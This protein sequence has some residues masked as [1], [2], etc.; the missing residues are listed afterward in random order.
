LIPIDH[1]SK[2]SSGHFQQ[3]W[4]PGGHGGVGGGEKAAAPLSDC[5]LEWMFNKLNESGSGLHFDED[6]IQIP[7]SPNQRLSLLLHSN[8]FKASRGGCRQL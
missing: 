3:A 6:R 8:V 5:A 7:M 1:M 2:I 4:F